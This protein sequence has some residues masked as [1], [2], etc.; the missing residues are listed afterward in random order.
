MIYLRK[1]IKTAQNCTNSSS[2]EL[3]VIIS[4]SLREEDELRRSGRRHLVGRK[5]PYAQGDDLRAGLAH[6]RPAGVAAE[7]D[8]VAREDAR[9]ATEQ[10]AR[11]GL[12][13]PPLL[14]HPDG[15][16]VA[17]DDRLDHVAADEGAKALQAPVRV[18]LHVH[19]DHFL[20]RRL[21]E[22]CFHCVVLLTVPR[23]SRCG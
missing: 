23:D 11:R 6:P 21:D 13:Q 16:A 19:R 2:K 4:D 8:A 7:Q 5:P 18:W 12:L 15:H 9:D 10:E 3:I 17:H 14:V 20:L 1:Y 22:Y